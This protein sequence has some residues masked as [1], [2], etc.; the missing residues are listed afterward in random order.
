VSGS[1]VLL[2]DLCTLRDLRTFVSRARVAD[3]EGVVRL[4]GHGAVLAVLASPLHGSGAPTVLGMRAATLTRPSRVDATVPMAAMEALLVDPCSDHE[5]PIGL[6][7]PADEI[8]DV[9]WAGITPPRSGWELLGTVSR[10]TLLRVA[11]AGE[12]EVA[13]AVSPGTAPHEVQRLRARVWGRSLTD[14]PPG[15]PAGIAFAAHVLGFVTDPDTDADGPEATAHRTGA[16][17]RLTTTRGH[18]LARTG[19]LI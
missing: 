4:I 5:G 19:S 9:A 3:P 11:R 15:L 2:P 18:I 8:T 10:E 16:W 17:S 12:A 6:A 1:T 7:V 13:A 14:D